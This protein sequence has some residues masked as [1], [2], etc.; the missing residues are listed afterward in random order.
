MDQEI[1][2]KLSEL[3]LKIDS[4]HR[5]V[6]QMRRYFLW[7]L[8]ISLALIVLPVLGLIFVLPQYLSTL[9]SLGT[10]GF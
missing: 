1:L 7:T 4:L 9:T 3:E 6:A 10:V 5:T 8:I 2:N